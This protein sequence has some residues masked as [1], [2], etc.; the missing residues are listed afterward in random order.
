MSRRCPIGHLTENFGRSVQHGMTGMSCAG[1]GEGR[2]EKHW[3]RPTLAKQRCQHVVDSTSAQ[4]SENGGASPPGEGQV[5]AWARS[6]ARL[7]TS[8]CLIWICLVSGPP[9][10]LGFL[11]KH[12]TR[13]IPHAFLRRP[14]LRL[15]DPYVGESRDGWR[16]LRTMFYSRRTGSLRCAVMSRRV[17]HENAAWSDPAGSLSDAPGT[18]RATPV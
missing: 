6:Q 15:P 3:R 5:T 2:S 12:R 9:Q 13:R 1:S 18:S 4:G 7:T 11:L 16:S 8:P 14:P 10:G 17:N